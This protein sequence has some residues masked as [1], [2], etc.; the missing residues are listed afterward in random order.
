MALLGRDGKRQKETYSRGHPF[1]S[2]E[3]VTPGRFRCTEC[4]HEHE[5]PPGSVTNLPVCPRCQN[6]YW[7]RARG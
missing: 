1:I 3:T 6:E 4:G 2:G 5:A 7:A